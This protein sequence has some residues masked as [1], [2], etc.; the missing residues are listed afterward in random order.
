MWFILQSVWSTPPYNEKKLNKAYR[1]SVCVS[2]RRE[3]VNVCLLLQDCRNVI[4]IYSVRE[5]GRFQG[6][7]K[8]THIEFVIKNIAV[9]ANISP[10]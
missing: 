4:L 6:M 9:L 7:Y 1:V 2:V 8:H 5:S 3:R 10:H